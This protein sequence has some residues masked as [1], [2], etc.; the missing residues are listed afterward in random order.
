MTLLWLS[1]FVGGSKA[2]I[3]ARSRCFPLYPRKRTQVGHRAMSEKCHQETY[4]QQQLTAHSITSS[5]LAINPAGISSLSAPAPSMGSERFAL[6]RKSPPS[7]RPAR[8][9]P[10]GHL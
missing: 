2:E 5:A 3:L 6:S 9:A 8:T 7:P 10:R 1:R 4:A